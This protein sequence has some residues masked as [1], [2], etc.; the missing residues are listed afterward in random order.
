MAALINFVATPLCLL[1]AVY[2]LYGSPDW[3]AAVV[4]TTTTYLLPGRRLTLMDDK[5]Y[6]F[7]SR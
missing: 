2:T 1:L 5:S 7:M 4:P 6:N 3:L